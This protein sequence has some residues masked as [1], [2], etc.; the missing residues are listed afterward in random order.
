MMVKHNDKATRK[1]GGNNQVDDHVSSTAPVWG[2][3]NPEWKH[4][5]TFREVRP[6][7]PIIR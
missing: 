6:L 5:D 7:R 2:T 4:E 1:Q 3:A